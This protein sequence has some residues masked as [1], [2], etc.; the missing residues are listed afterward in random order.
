MKGIIGTV[1]GTMLGFILSILSERFSRLRRFREQMVALL[2][3]L[4]ES[5]DETAFLNTTRH[6]VLIACAKI[7]GDV[8][9][10][11]R[12][13]FS[14]ARTDYCEMQARALKKTSDEFMR[15]QLQGG[16]SAAPDPDYKRRKREEM[17]NALQRLIDCAAAL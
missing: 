2:A 1:A 7:K 13:R 12:D 16:S 17:E 3:E 14:I 4:L 9:F 11:K 10:W 5:P 6:E 15:V 8:W